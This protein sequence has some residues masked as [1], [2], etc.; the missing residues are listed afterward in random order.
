MDI[1]GAVQSIDGHNAVK[2]VI[3]ITSEKDVDGIERY[4]QASAVATRPN[5]EVLADLLKIAKSK[6][7]NDRVRQTLIQAIGSMAFR[8]ARLPNET[9]NSE[10]VQDVEK[11]LTTSLKKCPNVI[12]REP[13]LR[14]LQTLQSVETIEQLLEYV[15]DNEITV[16]VT[17]MKALKSFPKR[18][19]TPTHRHRFEDIFFQKNQRYDS[20]VRTLAIDILLDLNP[21]VAQLKK[22]L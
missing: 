10:I 15:D 14:G 4:L 7:S 5:Y 3:G 18:V 19:W 22:L 11:Y 6:V 21:S 16:S 9:Y 12:C 1:F 17:A 20:S 13:F 2:E 8:Y